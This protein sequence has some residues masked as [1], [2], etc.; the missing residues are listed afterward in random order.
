MKLAVAI[1]CADPLLGQRLSVL[2]GVLFASSGQANEAD[3]D[4]YVSYSVVQFIVLSGCKDQYLLLAGRLHT[5]RT[6]S[7]SL[8][9]YV[10]GRKNALFAETIA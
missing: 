1:H 6:G 5:R 3:D 8:S 4:L 10:G 7:T 9:G 2:A